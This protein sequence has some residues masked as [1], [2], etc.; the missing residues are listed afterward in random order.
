MSVG[1]DLLRYDKKRKYLLLDV[2]TTGL[3]LSYALPWQLSYTLFTLDKVIETADFYIWWDNLPISDGAARITR[4]NPEEYRRRAMEPDV[5]LTSFEKLLYSPEIYPVGH[6]V[7][8]YDSMI[9]SVWRRK[10]GLREDYS[11]LPRTLDT[12]ALSKAY[13]KGV[14][15]DRNNLLAAQYRALGIVEK[16]LKTSLGV[17]GKELGIEHDS[18]HLH[19]ARADI[20]LNVEV[21]KQ[22]L[23]KMEI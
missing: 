13:K 14:A 4:F 1:A 5:V 10:L 16:G 23:W 18:S 11:Y 15:L 7:L 6:N 3:N 17:M 20:E 21:F 9:H 12:L 19:D 22:L 8:G 2:E